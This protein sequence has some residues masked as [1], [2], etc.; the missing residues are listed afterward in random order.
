M[1]ASKA[2]FQ[3]PEYDTTL[4]CRRHAVLRPHSHVAQSTPLCR[5]RKTGND[6]T[7]SIPGSARL[8]R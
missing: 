3:A 1:I 2:G 5:N 7:D 4:S 8:P 6:K